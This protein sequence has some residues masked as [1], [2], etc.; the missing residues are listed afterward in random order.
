MLSV[1]GLAMGWTVWGSKPG[2]C[3]ISAPVQTSPGAHQASN[4]MGN[5]NFPGVKQPGH[6]VYHPSPSSAEVKERA[7]LYLYSHSGLLWPF[8]G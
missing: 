3:K 8:L 1:W 7:Q 5:R 6:D 2:G 4:T